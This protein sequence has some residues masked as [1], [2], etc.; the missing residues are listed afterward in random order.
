M[1][2]SATDQKL[3]CLVA[4]AFAFALLCPLL[5]TGLHAAGPAEARAFPLAKLFKLLTTEKAQPY[6]IS[7]LMRAYLGTLSR[8]TDTDA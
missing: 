5:P 8:M 6:D 2:E 4:L 3:V 7:R 1:C